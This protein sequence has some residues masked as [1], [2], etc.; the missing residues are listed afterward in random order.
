MSDL[1]DPLPPIRAVEVQPGEFRIEFD[2]GVAEALGFNAEFD[3]R[4]FAGPGGRNAADAY[5]QMLLA[6]LVRIGRGA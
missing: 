3:L 6:R 4:L 1:P 2:D 5:C